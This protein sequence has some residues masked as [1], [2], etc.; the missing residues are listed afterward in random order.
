MTHNRDA[1]EVI[2]TRLKF[3][4]SNV[5]EK[6]SNPSEKPEACDQVHNDP[7]RIEESIQPLDK[8]DDKS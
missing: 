7:S 8:S 6:T 5:S 3:R 4:Y 1:Q 2:H